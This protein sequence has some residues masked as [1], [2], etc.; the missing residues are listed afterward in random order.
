M[1]RNLALACVLTLAPAALV[2]LAQQ[3][4]REA[5]APAVKD[6]ARYDELFDDF[7]ARRKVLITRFERLQQA[8]RVDPEE[9]RKAEG[10]LVALDREYAAALRRYIDTHAG[11][12]DLMP[13]RFELC[14]TLSRLEDRLA[15]AVAAAD[16][17]LKNHPDA[18]LVPDARFVR[19]QTLFRMPGREDDALAALELFIEK[20]PERQDADAARMMR[21]RALLFLN[22]VADA[23]R[24]LEALVKSD[25]V[26]NDKE[27]RAFLQAQ[28]DALDWIGR[29]L[30]AFDLKAADGKPATSGELAGKPAL[31]FVWDTTSSACLG[32]LPFVQELH[33]RHA[34]R[35]NVIGISVNESQA[36]FE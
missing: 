5:P 33:R 31:V 34:D 20:H 2:P 17:F 23:R 32:E 28:L 1:I 26:R 14:V 22:R 21:V 9:L 16:E 35:I 10:E 30:P 8:Q 18:E 12:K 6:F 36:A 19:A 7:D 11:A 24:S 25:R 4:P 13:A 15:D 3:A 29:D 27:A